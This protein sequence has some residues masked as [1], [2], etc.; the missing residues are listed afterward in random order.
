MKQ[1]IEEALALIILAAGITS[2]VYYHKTW[3]KK[4]EHHR[5]V[6]EF[7]QIGEILMHGQKT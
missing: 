1:R 3:T 6:Q 5:E 2:M 7:D 4:I